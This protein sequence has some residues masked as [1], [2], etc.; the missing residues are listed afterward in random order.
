MKT[1]DGTGQMQYHNFAST[2]NEYPK[3]SNCGR[4]SVGRMLPCQGRG[5]G[6]ESPRPL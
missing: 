5:Q 4:G 1:L 6:F 2:G 3:G